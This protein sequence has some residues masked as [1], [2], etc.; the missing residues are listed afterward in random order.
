MLILLCTVFIYRPRMN[1]RQIDLNLL[2][3]F[4]ALTRER[5]V[6]RAARALGITQ[7]A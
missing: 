5:N 2:V 7:P 1:L 6:S 4:D 3:A